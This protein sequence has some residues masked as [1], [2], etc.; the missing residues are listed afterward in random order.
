M[1]IFTRVYN[2]LVDVNQWYLKTSE[3]ALDQAYNAALRIKSIE[4]EYFEGEK[5][6]T[7]SDRY[8]PS[9][10]A[11]FKI[12]L[13]N[14]LKV[15]RTR[16]IEFK[17][18]SSFLGAIDRN[19]HALESQDR[20]L[21]PYFGGDRSSVI[22]DKLKFID[23]LQSRYTTQLNIS[24]PENNGQSVSLIRSE[25]A[26]IRLDGTSQRKYL[27]KNLI[28]D[29]E[30]VT[31]KTGVLPRSIL[32]TVNRIKRELDPKAEAEVVKNFRSSKNRT[33]ISLR[34]ILMI[35]L[36]P[37]LAQQVS[38]NFIVGPIVDQLNIVKVDPFLNF[39]ME[40]EAL[41]KLEV[42]EAKLKFQNVI[43]DAPEL[44]SAYIRGKV[45]LRAM[46]L[47][48]EYS[49]SS[50][51]A[52]KNVFAD[53]MSLIVFTIVVVFRR[54]DFEVIKSFID[55]LIYGLSD[56]AKAFIIILSTDIFVGFHSPHGWEILLEGILHHLGLPNNREFIFL[57][58]A[59][60]PVILDTVFKYWI[61]RFLNRIS[62]SAVAT[63]KSMNE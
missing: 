26:Q 35:S 13:K 48:E 16:L 3:R 23:H 20:S 1:S 29:V 22:L 49:R 58:I 8:G 62:P 54:K 55:E 4:D 10:L 40:D 60:F 2:Y 19:V 38:K 18:S 24:T 42:F 50:N 6:P 25:S 5:I 43:S 11:Y 27:G 37:L 14:Y 28:T 7:V 12:E 30:T 34:F 44:G 56:S 52:I 59:T 9:E 31:D 63:Y 21:E 17:A 53:L 47:A 39:D 15:I 45:R 51:N 32:G 57:F 36:V 33:I 46:E 41:H 61:F